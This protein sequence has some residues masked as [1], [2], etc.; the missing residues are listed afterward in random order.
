MA[1]AF[2]AA[3]FC[4]SMNYRIN[5]SDNN[6]SNWHQLKGHIQISILSLF[7][8]S[9]TPALGA[10]AGISATVTVEVVGIVVTDV[11]TVLVGVTAT[12]PVGTVGKTVATLFILVTPTKFVVNKG[13]A[14][15]VAVGTLENDI[16]I[17]FVTCCNNYVR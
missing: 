15:K 10:A 3:V 17:R 8:P 4:T 9:V 2:S 13:F 7:L 16:V 6:V 5:N 11:R 1:A 14:A 12:T